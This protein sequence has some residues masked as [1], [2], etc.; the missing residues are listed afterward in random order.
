M[1]S[2][3]LAMLAHFLHSLSQDLTIHSNAR[4]FLLIFHSLCAVGLVFV[5]TPFH[6]EAQESPVTSYE[7]HYYLQVI[8]I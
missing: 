3:F 4:Q 5:L 7:A 1:V 2:F 8:F 6:S